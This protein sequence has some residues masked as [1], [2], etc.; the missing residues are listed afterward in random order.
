[1]G[2]LFTTHQ[3]YFLAPLP[4]TQK[5]NLPRQLGAIKQQ[6]RYFLAPLPGRK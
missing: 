5:N 6:S 4:G 2:W 1:M 3:A